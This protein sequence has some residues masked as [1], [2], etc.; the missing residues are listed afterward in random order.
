MQ[1]CLFDLIIHCGFAFER[2]GNHGSGEERRVPMMIH[3]VGL[4][5]TSAKSVCNECADIGQQ[6]SATLHFN[7]S[8]SGLYSVLVL[9][10]QY[11]MKKLRD[12]IGT[13][14]V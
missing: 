1:V 10:H 12:L 7:A 2:T 3:K 11:C 14:G 6:Y 5:C 13:S 4:S 9:M 8:S